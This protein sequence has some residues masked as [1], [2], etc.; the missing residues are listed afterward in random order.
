MRISFYTLGCK[1]NQAETDE[2]K[3]DL[4]KKGFTATDFLSDEDVAVIRACGVTCGASQTT[5]EVIR[6]AKRQGSYVIATGCLE[7]RDLKEIDFAA[8]SSEE[9]VNHLESLTLKMEPELACSVNEKMLN[10]TRALIKIQNGCNFQCSYCI[11][12]S[13]RGKSTSVP[14]NEVI[15]KVKEAETQGFKEVVLTG[16]NI[17]LYKDGKKGLAE[18]LETILAETNLP[19]IRLG[20]LDP[21]LITPKLL[22]LFSF[23]YQT[24]DEYQKRLMPQWHLALQSGSNKILEGMNRFYTAE[25]YLKIVEKIYSHNPLFSFTTDIIVGFPGETAADFK[26]TEEIIKKVKFSKV[27]VFPFSP[28][29]ETIAASAKPMIQEKIRSERTKKLIQEVTKLKKEYQNKFLGQTR[30][31]LFENKNPRTGL[32][33]GYTPEYLKIK[34][35]SRVNLTNKIV[36]L[37]LNKSLFV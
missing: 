26:A 9:I 2:L 6:R 20:S 27:H 5:R 7:N 30:G 8:T 31:V 14:T 12:P 37:K 17:C 19:R 33:E 15:K 21:R 28:R 10:R 25:K 3:K 13:F 16:V 34:K 29:P 36:S 24:A 32:Y 35:S 18:L 23:D 4:L 1:L 11:V 22:E